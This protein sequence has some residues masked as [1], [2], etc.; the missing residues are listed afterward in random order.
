[1]T[2]ISYPYTLVG[3]QPENVNQLNSNL[4]AVESVVNGNLDADNLSASANIVGSQLSSSAGIVSGQLADATVTDTKL[5]SPN[6]STRK[7]ILDAGGY[8]GGATTGAWAWIPTSGTSFTISTGFATTATPPPLWQ[9]VTADHAVANK[10]TNFRVD[11][12]VAV[13]STSPS[14]VVITAGLYAVTISGGSYVFTLVSGSTAGSSGLATNTISKF[15]S[16]TFAASALTTTSMYTFGVAVTSINVPL[17]I[18]ANFQLVRNN[19]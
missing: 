1:V 12:Q 11:M 9:F 19:T 14:T 5:A 18:S 6:N 7:T 13:G 10:T 4:S 8:L 2:Q 3:L 15:S 16:S 17:G